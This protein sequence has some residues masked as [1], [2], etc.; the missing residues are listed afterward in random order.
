MLDKKLSNLRF[1]AFLVIFSFGNATA[2][3]DAPRFYENKAQGWFWY[4][5]E[6]AEP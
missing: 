3:Q 4:E 5:P 1:W 2:A 6:P